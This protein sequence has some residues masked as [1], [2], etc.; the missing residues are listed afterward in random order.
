[1]E[2]QELSQNDTPFGFALA[3][4]TRRQFTVTLDVAGAQYLLDH[5]HPRQ[6]LVSPE[7]VSAHARKMRDGTFVELMQPGIYVDRAG[8]VCNA[9]HRLLAQVETERTYR[10]NMVVGASS[11]EIAA[12][13]QTRP[14]R[15]HQSYNLTDRG[16]R[17]TAREEAVIRQY[18]RMQCSDD[19][20]TFHVTRIDPDD[21]AEFRGGPFSQDVTLVLSQTPP[22]IA[23]APAIAAI[24]YARPINQ[25]SIDGFLRGFLD[26]R[27]ALPTS[28]SPNAPPVALARW[29][30]THGGTGAGGRYVDGILI[31]TLSALRAHLQ[32]RDIGHL[33]PTGTPLAYLKKRRED[34]GLE[35]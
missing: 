11:D 35:G 22:R 5:M 26:S 8:F 25:H 6:R 21:L 1:M 10:W 9:R 3:T 34:I 2:I 14:R 32:G 4:E 33:Q 23:S 15:A 27:L 24:A 20:P 29:F 13:D 16:G 18:I 12:L 19:T 7:H 28:L 31:R 30:N 17:M